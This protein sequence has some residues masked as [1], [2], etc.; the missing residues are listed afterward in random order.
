MLKGRVA[1]APLQAQC[2]AKVFKM[3]GSGVVSLSQTAVTHTR[4][5]THTHTHTHTNREIPDH[6]VLFLKDLPPEE[7]PS[8]FTQPKPSTHETVS[9][10]PLTLPGTVK[11][12]SEEEVFDVTVTYIS[13]VTSFYVQIYGKNHSVSTLTLSP[14]VYSI[15]RRV[16][17]G[18]KFGD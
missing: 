1:S 9:S 3:N 15:A 13:S 6:P 8:S 14:C 4:T 5:H 16:D 18:Q 17:E 2:S 11:F 10:L 12:T 7:R